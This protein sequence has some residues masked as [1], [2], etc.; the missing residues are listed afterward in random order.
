[1]VTGGL[2]QLG[3]H[4]AKHVELATSQGV[5]YAT[6][7]LLPMGVL[8]VLEVPPNLRPAIPRAVQVF[9][10]LLRKHVITYD[11]DILA[12]QQRITKIVQTN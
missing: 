7:Q 6:T 3:Q 2:G 5:A 4:A 10:A 8:P 9:Q 12:Y 1:M 11:S